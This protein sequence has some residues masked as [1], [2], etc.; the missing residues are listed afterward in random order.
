MSKDGGWGYSWQGCCPGLM[1]GTKR[2]RVAR[3]GEDCWPC[4]Q[5]AQRVQRRKGRLQCGVELCCEQ[6]EVVLRPNAWWWWVMT[7]RGSHLC[8]VVRAGGC[9][10]VIMGATPHPWGARGTWGCMGTLCWC[11]GRASRRVYGTVGGTSG[12]GPRDAKHRG[13]APL[14]AFHACSY[15]IHDTVAVHKSCCR[16]P[17]LSAAACVTFCQQCKPMND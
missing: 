5:C 13:G 17:L 2:W 4:C 10:R 9:W 7:V 1:G 6:P 3:G 16:G 14:V 15:G 12:M 11:E 8:G